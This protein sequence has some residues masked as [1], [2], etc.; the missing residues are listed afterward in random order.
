MPKTAARTL[1]R[2]LT[3]AILFTTLCGCRIVAAPPPY[4]EYA[5]AKAAVRA[6][7]DADSARFATSLWNKAEENFRNGQRA[8]REANFEEAKKHFQLALRFAEK[9]ENLTRL[10]KFQTGENFP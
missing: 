1:C 2:S 6:A 10:K 4:E 3:S 5:L 8:Y 9:A 7:Q